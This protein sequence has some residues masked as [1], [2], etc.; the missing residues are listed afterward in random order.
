MTIKKIDRSICKNLRV[1]IEQGL[2]YLKPT[3]GLNIKAG[4]ASYT[5]NSVTFKLELTV[6]GFDKDKDTFKQ[7]C[8]FYNLTPDDY[9]REFRSQGK[10]FRLIGIN[11]RSP[12][13]CFLGERSDGKRFKFTDKILEQFA[14]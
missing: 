9:G 5:D 2:E 8:T 6:V 11:S 14:A 3:Y 10:A 12:K 13:F 7:L 4:N 1:E